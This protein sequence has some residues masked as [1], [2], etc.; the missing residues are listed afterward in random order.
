MTRGKIGRFQVMALLQ[1]AR[2]Y[3]LKGDLDKAKSFGLNR[4]I[5]YAWA[6]RTGGRPRRRYAAGAA[7]SSMPAPSRSIE[8]VGNEAAYITE[9]G[10]F[11]I[12]DEVQRPEDYNREI[13]QRI[14]S[15]VPYGEAWKAALNYLK[16]FPREVLLDQR[17]FYEKA[18]LPVRDHFDE[19][20]KRFSK[21]SG[22][23]EMLS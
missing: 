23:E 18:Y 1:A 15:F 20:I 14:E 7:A 2:Y 8:R 4:A 5:F 6:K 19:V 10:L 9:S 22:L 13:V 11:T 17:Q 21:S 3:L 12:G 16:T